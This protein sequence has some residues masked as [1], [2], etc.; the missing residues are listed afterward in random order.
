MLDMNVQAV[1]VEGTLQPDGTLQL[2]QKPNL[3][4]G[5]DAVKT[6]LTATIEGG[7]LKP[8]VALPFPES[9]RVKLTIEPVDAEN[10][11]AAAWQRLKERIRQQP[12]GGLA[13]NF[14]REDLYERD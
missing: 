2:D 12:I 4:T 8:D 14:S 13:T 9:T 7:V 10:T 6:E 11:A 1:T 3:T 5:A